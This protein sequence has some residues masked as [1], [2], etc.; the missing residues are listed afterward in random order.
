MKLGLVDVDWGYI[1]AVLARGNDDDQAF[2]LKAFVKECKAWGTAHQI[3]MQ[4]CGV[5]EKLTKE[6]R[7]TLSM[8]SYED[9]P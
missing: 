4:L 7:E 8:I 6:E 1:G 2:F 3:Q 5:N 9:N